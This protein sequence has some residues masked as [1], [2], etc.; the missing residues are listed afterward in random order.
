MKML[1]TV[2]EI[3]FESIIRFLMVM[4]ILIWAI[5]VFAVACGDILVSAK[6]LIALALIAFIGSL[7][8]TTIEYFINKRKGE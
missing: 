4:L 8:I 5:F 1:D 6:F 7:I 3:V 2:I